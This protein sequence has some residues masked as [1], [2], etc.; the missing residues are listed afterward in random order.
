MV[1]N[2]WKNFKR[3]R[4]ET[5]I[6]K[7]TLHDLRRSAITNWAQSLPIQ[8]VQELAGHLD[9]ATTRRYYL[10]VRPD[11]MAAANKTINN[12]LESGSTH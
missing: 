6:L 12:I 1:N 4:Q 9:I 2:M 8:V 5:G 7:C 10:A 11:D 3:F